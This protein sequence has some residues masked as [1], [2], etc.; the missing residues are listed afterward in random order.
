MSRPV[1]DMSGVGN[2]PVVIS[3]VVSIPVVVISYVVGIPV[4]VI[5]YVVNISVVV[6][7]LLP[8]PDKKIA[9]KKTSPGILLLFISV[10]LR[11]FHKFI[12]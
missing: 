6:L 3:Y 10:L 8:H 12:N 5:S 1:L 2:L 7:L 11:V 4:V 9:S